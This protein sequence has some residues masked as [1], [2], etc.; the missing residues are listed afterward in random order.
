MNNNDD[1][2]MIAMEV[3]VPEELYRAMTEYVDRSKKSF[4]EV[5]QE[6]ITL[7]LNTRNL[8]AVIT[9]LQDQFKL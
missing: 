9:T 3:E 4:S 5:Y 2:T 8:T 6:A 1:M 7:W